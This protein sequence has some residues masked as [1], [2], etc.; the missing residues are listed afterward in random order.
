MFTAGA[1]LGMNLTQNFGRPLDT[2]FNK[3][4]V[5]WNSYGWPYFVRV[6]ATIDFGPGASGTYR[7]FDYKALAIDIAAALA[8]LTGVASVCEFAQHR[9]KAH[10]K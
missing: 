10:D 4:T 7:R 8:I 1:I 9:R 2:R 5:V 3:P 6:D